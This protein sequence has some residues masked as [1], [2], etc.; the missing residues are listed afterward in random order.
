MKIG[1]M[2][3]AVPANVHVLQRLIDLDILLKRFLLRQIIELLRYLMV[4]RVIIL[5]GILIHVALSDLVT[6]QILI[7]LIARPRDG[8]L[9]DGT[10]QVGI[11]RQFVGGVLALFAASF[12]ISLSTFVRDVPL[13][14]IDSANLCHALVLGA[15]AFAIRFFFSDGLFHQWFFNFSADRIYLSRVIHETPDLAPLKFALI[16]LR[17]SAIRNH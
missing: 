10:D 12:T 9:I 6:I 5:E 11:I 2:S 15:L 8:A 16:D 7:L 13:R 4:E 3:T 14:G 1:L 17:A